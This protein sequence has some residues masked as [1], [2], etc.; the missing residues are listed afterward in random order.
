MRDTD[1]ERAAWQKQRTNEIDELRKELSEAHAALRRKT[2]ELR[3]VRKNAGV[4]IESRREVE[5]FFADA[6][7]MVRDEMT[8]Q[9]VEEQEKEKRARMQWIRDLA[10]GN[11]GQ[12]GEETLY[13]PP[14]APSRSL[15]VRDLT[16]E[17]RYKI[18]RL[19][20]ARIKGI[21]TTASGPRRSSREND[22]EGIDAIDIDNAPPETPAIAMI[23]QKSSVQ[24]RE[25][26][27]ANRVAR[28]NGINNSTSYVSGRGREGVSREGRDSRP[29]APRPETPQ[30]AGPIT[31]FPPRP[32]SEDLEWN[33]DDTTDG[34]APPSKAPS[35]MGRSRR[36]GGIGEE[37]SIE[38]S[39]KGNAFFLTEEGGAEGH[40]DMPFE[41]F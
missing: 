10:C 14:L 40:D 21:P 4:L 38:T 27:I 16:P 34:S 33:G 23:P 5:I 41:R 11:G 2:E 22:R 30:S 29:N 18:L 20:M 8:Q 19:M 12:G 15:D 37:S 7:Q 1:V 39:R 32:T 17:Q 13:L 9:V 24:S 26:T 31:H 6:L 28:M 35:A 25:G 3:V 36:D